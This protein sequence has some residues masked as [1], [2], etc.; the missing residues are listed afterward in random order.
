MGRIEAADRAQYVAALRRRLADLEHDMYI[1]DAIMAAN[2]KN[3][4]AGDVEV[5][6]WRRLESEALHAAIAELDGDQMRSIPIWLYLALLMMVS[7]A[8]V[9]AGV[10]LWMQ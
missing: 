2:P 8:I 6:R 9:L 10:A 1:N 4:T 3:A 7:V 5:A